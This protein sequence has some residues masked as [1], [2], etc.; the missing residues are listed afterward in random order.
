MFKKYRHWWQL[1]LLGMVAVGFIFI[2]GWLGFASVL[3]GGSAW[4]IPNLYFFWKIKRVRITFDNKKMVKTF[5]QSEAVK[6]A[7]SF[8]IIAL[9]LSLYNIDCL[10]FLCGYIFTI[11]VSFLLS[12]QLGVEND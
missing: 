10:S 2:K 3:L 4:F 5:F 1:V 6:L 9:I 12:L 8:S 7:L 11:T